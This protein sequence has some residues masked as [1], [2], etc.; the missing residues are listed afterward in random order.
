MGGG[1]VGVVEGAVGVVSGEAKEQLLSLASREDL[2]E[3]LGR[4]YSAYVLVTEQGQKKKSEDADTNHVAYF[5][6][7]SR[8]IG[9]L[10]RGKVRM[11][12]Q[13]RPEWAEGLF[14]RG[15]LGYG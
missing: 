12:N 1:A 8:A 14:D 6:G 2:L 10:E 11:L 4:R 7:F 15:D 5:G 9:M 13:L 3:E